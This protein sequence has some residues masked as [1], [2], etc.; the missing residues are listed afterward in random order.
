ML[1]QYQLAPPLLARFEN[2]L[3]YKFI[4]GRV[5]ESKDLGREQISRGVA[6]KLGEWHGVLPITSV[7]ESNGVDHPNGAPASS[8]HVSK[9]ASAAFQWI[10]SITPQ[11]VVPNLWTVLQKWILAL[12]T[13]T[14]QERTR[15]D[16]LQKELERIV[17]EFG[18]LEGLGEDGVCSLCKTPSA[19]SADSMASSSSLDIAIFFLV[20]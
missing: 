13:G 12:P 16:D 11:M 4:Q 6:R 14:E 2:G 17:P 18:N 20:T 3:L 5:C 19:T 7:G 8:A 15:N 9:K 10:T 1:A